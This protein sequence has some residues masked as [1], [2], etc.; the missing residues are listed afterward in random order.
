MVEKAAAAAAVPLPAMDLAVAMAANGVEQ[1]VAV[2]PL[3]TALAIQALVA[4]AL[5]ALLL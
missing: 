4:R 1:V 5:K 2:A 3:W